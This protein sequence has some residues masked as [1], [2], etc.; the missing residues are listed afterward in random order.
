MMLLAFASSAYSQNDDYYVRQAE[1]Y[2]RDAEYYTRKA[3]SY[4]REAEYYNRQAQNYL[5]EAEYYSRQNKPDKVK[6]YMRW[7]QEATDKVEQRKKWAADAREK[8]E[9]RMKWAQEALRKAGRR[10][11]MIGKDVKS[12]KATVKQQDVIFLQKKWQNV[13]RLWENVY[14]CSRNKTNDDKMKN[15]NLLNGIII[16]RLRN[17]V[18]SG[19]VFL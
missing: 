9:Q 1:S 12:C 18:G 19:K 15:L 17:V 3:E 4:E 8:A 5:R 6:T 14:L 2:M 16:I 13:C 7:A 10:W 11:D